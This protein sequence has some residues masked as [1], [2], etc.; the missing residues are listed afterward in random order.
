MPFNKT[1]GSVNDEEELLAALRSFMVVTLGWTESASAIQGGHTFKVLSSTG[2]SGT[3]SVFVG[4][5]S[6]YKNATDLATLQFNAYTGFCST[7]HG[8]VC[9]C[10]SI[11]HGCA[12][13]P[14]QEG[15]LGL[16]GLALSHGAIGTTFWFYGDKDCVIIVIRNGVYYHGAYLGL[17]GRFLAEVNDE[18]PI[19]LAGTQH[20]CVN[21]CAYDSLLQ[22]WPF[23]FSANF[24]PRFIRDRASTAWCCSRYVCCKV[25]GLAN[26]AYGFLNNVEQQ[27]SAFGGDYSLDPIHVSMSDGMRG[28]MKY[29]YSIGY[30]GLIAG[31]TISVGGNSYKVFP[32]TL[33]L[34]SN[35]WLA[36]RDYS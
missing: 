26:I 14:T 31:S 32:N 1:T 18:Y 10:N 20:W 12:C 11:C 15:W 24:S 9:Q 28:A 19:Y 5:Y 16:P 21:Y 35:R 17:V 6:T 33:G 13:N 29:V 8:F 25:T 30:G 23:A 34:D 2:E 7:G 27:P 3:E 22:S 4:F 36:V